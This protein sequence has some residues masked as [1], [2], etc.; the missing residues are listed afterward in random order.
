[1]FRKRGLNTASTFRGGTEYD[2]MV[3]RWHC[4]VAKICRLLN[5]SN[6]D[7]NV[8]VL[9]FLVS[10]NYF[11]VIC[12]LCVCTC[13]WVPMQDRRGW[14]IHLLDLGS[15]AVVSHPKLVLEIKFR[16]FER[17]ASSLKYWPISS[18][19][20][21]MPAKTHYRWFWGFGTVVAQETAFGTGVLKVKLLRGET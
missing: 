10:L 16:S 5:N 1:M 7:L 14:W 12:M 6:A 21:H 13:V 19:P 8:F 4:M 11:S 3:D 15:K 9:F 2:S 18:V 17:A 20:V